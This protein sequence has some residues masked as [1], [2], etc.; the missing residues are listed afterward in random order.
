MPLDRRTFSIGALGGIAALGGCGLPEFANASRSATSKNFLL[1][2]VDDLN[3]WVTALGEHPQ[4][5]APNMQSLAASGTAFANAH[6]Q[7]PIC[8]P[9][10]ASMFSGLYPAQTGIYGQISDDQLGPAVAAV[11]STL[12]LPQ[13][14]RAQGYHAGGAGKVSHQGAQ[15]GMFDEYLESEL[16]YG[17]NPPRRF[18]WFDT[19]THTDWGAYP[20]TDEEMRDHQTASWGVDFLARQGEQPF[21]LALGFVRPH[22][23]WYV[24]KRWLDMFPL[25]QIELPVVR[26]NDLDDVPRAGRDLAAV[27][28]MP[29]LEWAMENDE[30]RPIMQGYLASIAFADHCIG[31]AIAG[32]REYG[33][34]DNTLVCLVSDNGYHL[35]E[36]QRFAKMSLWERSTR[37][38]LIFCGPGIETQ[39]ATDPVGLI[40]IFP[41]V[42]DMLRLPTNPENAGRSLRPI[43]AEGGKLPLQPQLSVYGEGNY[44]V[45][46]DRYRYIRYVDG[47]EELYDHESDPMEWHNLAARS[48]LATVKSRLAAHIPASARPDVMQ[49]GEGA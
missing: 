46:D 10:R 36:K 40:D 11:S 8:G 30:W 21:M 34:S 9:S 6:A 5:R 24:P 44:A 43:L 1:L 20:A 16:E 27:P 15:E 4:V 3:D 7:A 25:E 47:S 35:G 17:P 42:L 33:F 2:I 23:P 49:A 45:A 29:T 31:M 39:V 19:R 22:V 32:L 12:L 14:L 28:Q 48:D 13:Y 26:D 18:K 38:P 37:V 41:T